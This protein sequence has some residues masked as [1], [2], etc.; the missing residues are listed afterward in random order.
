MKRIDSLDGLPT[1]TEPYV[2]DQVAE[3][4]NDIRSLPS[5][6]RAL[7]TNC[8]GRIIDVGPGEG[9]SSMALA[10]IAPSTQI[11]GIEMDQMH[12]RAAWPKCK[13]YPNLQL[14]W[15]ALPGTPSNPLVDNRLPTPPTARLSDNHCSVLF[16]WIGMSRRDIFEGHGTWSRIVGDTGVFIVPRFWREGP[17]FLQTRDRDN[18]ERLCSQLGAPLPM[19][20]P[21]KGISSFPK[22]NCQKLANTIKA[23][24]WVLWLTGVFDDLQVSLWETLIDRWQD[25]PRYQLPEILLELEVIVAHRQ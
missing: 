6:V 5:D 24:G 15:G 7:L 10:D 25:A 17:G 8:K 1:A 21:Y 20:P 3:K 16:S 23:R 22:M 13:E 2:E 19:W 12:L 14:Y 4:V 11:L 18:L 9:V